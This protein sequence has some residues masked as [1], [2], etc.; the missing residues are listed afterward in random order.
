MV[1]HGQTIELKRRAPNGGR[2]WAYRYRTGGRDSKRVQRGGFA[3]EQDARDALER[4]LERLRRERRIT[5]RP[6]LSELV[7]TYLDQHDVQPVTIEKLRYVLSKATAVFGDRKIGELTSQEIAEWRVGLSPGYRFEATRA[8]RQVLH[9]A[10]AW[11]MLDI[12]PAKVGVDNPVRRQKEQHPFEILGGAGSTRR[13][14][15]GEPLL[16]MRSSASSARARDQAP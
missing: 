1:Q 12:N 7:E 2:L 5:R 13:G 16:R 3:S 11:G 9:R 6:T 10:V 15:N 14:S 8:L 4:E